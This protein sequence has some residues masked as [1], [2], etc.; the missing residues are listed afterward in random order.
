MTARSAALRGCPPMFGTRLGL[1]F[2]VGLVLAVAAFGRPAQDGKQQDEDAAAKEK[3]AQAEAQAKEAQGTQPAR[4]IPPAVQPTNTR[5]AVNPAQAQPVQPNKTPARPAGGQRGAPNPLQAPTGPSAPQSASQ[6]GQVPYIQEVGDFFVINLDETGEGI[7]LEWLTKMCQVA[8]GKN[9]VYDDQIQTLL[10]QQ[11]VRMFGEKR[12]AKDEFFSFY[13][14]LMFI[15]QFTLTKVGPDHMAVYLVQSLAQPNAQKQNLKNEAIYLTP[16]ELDRYADQVATQ[17]I[18]VLHLPHVDVRTLGNSLRGIT[19]DPSGGQ[20]ILPV[21]NTNSVILQGFASNVAAIARILL[22]VDAES[23]KETGVSPL[24]EVIP[25]EFAAAEDLSDILGELLEASKRLQQNQ[26]QA[27]AA[28]GA[29]PT[30]TNGGETKILTYSPTNSLLVMALPD[31]MQA[32]KELV[33]RLD[34]EVVEPERTYHVY[35]LKHAKAEELSEVLEEFIEGAS[36]VSGG[37]GGSRGGGGGQGAAPATPG[38]SSRDNEVIVVPD[39]STNSLLIAASRRRYEEVEELINRLDDRQDQVLIE[40]ALIELT[41]SD[42]LDIGIELGG[43]D[44][45]SGFGVTSFGLST[46]QDTDG[47]GIPDVKIPTPR[48]DGQPAVG[49]TAGIINGSDFGMPVLL[50][51]LQGRSNTNVLNIPSVLVTNNGSA[52]VEA[53]DEQPTGSSTLSGNNSQSGFNNYVDAGVTMKISPSISASG[54]LRLDIELEVSNFSSDPNPGD[55]LPPPK[56]VRTLLTS[57]NVPNG[58][59]MVIGGIKIDNKRHSR[60]GVPWL[61]DV[62]LLGYLFRRDTDTANETTLYYFVTPHILKERNFADLSEI[63][64]KTKLEAAEKIGTDRVQMIDE[65]FGRSG[66]ATELQGFEVPM[67]RSPGGGEASMEM[68]GQDPLKRMEMLERQTPAQPTPAP[69][70]APAPEPPPADDQS[71]DEEVVPPVT[72]PPATSNSGGGGR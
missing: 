41:G 56:T 8:T 48:A 72:P 63:S 35:V 52:T 64:Y 65:G 51:A 9:F 45:D 21:G 68:V 25:V 55:N 61:A 60:S 53:K 22:L 17:V 40:T 42:T 49:V 37:P 12:I 38:L 43:A 33:A 67:Y 10:K 44:V 36:R 39:E 34:V 26:R 13:Q 4:P 29:G 30:Q 31:D 6:T 69:A 2:A 58:D 46:F 66:K 54:Y 50:A 62:P 15:Y 16:D 70:P 11:K 57:V 28:A 27:Q 19:S 3:A 1:K 7:D 18:T 59:T 14:M 23:A 71:V 24:F 5:P 20:G 47:D 32:I